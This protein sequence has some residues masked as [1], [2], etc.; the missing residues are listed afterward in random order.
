MNE[1]LRFAK[2]HDRYTFNK[3]DLAR[4]AKKCSGAFNNPNWRKPWDR[5]VAL[6]IFK[7]AQGENGKVFKHKFCVAIPKESIEQKMSHLTDSGMDTRGS[8]P[9]AEAKPEITKDED[10][11]TEKEEPT[12]QDPSPATLEVYNAQRAEVI[13]QIAVI[14]ISILKKKAEAQELYKLLNEITA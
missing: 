7:H 14:N 13:R 10:I 6:G 12:E 1:L 8:K 2:D 5:L 4:V 3:S 11:I 9:E